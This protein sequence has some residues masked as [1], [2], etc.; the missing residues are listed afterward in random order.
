MLSNLN[1]KTFLL[2]ELYIKLHNRYDE[3]FKIDIG[4]TCD[5]A[6]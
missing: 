4:L 2:L 5:L 3:L 6:N 1:L